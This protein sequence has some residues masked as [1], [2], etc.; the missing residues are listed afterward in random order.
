[1][2]NGNVGNG[3]TATVITSNGHK[4][5]CENG[6]GT[7]DDSNDLSTKEILEALLI[8]EKQNENN[9]N[10]SNILSNGNVKDAFG[11]DR[12]Y[13]HNDDHD[14]HGEDSIDHYEYYRL[15]VVRVAGQSIAINEIEETHLPLM[16]Q[17][18]RDDFVR[19]SHEVYKHL[20]D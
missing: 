4:K 8:Y 10:V 2:L 15:P 17:A 7:N 11:K 5:V 19:L 20:Y 14:D 16:S 18:E 9:A 6:N 12:H 3:M 1:L 13:D